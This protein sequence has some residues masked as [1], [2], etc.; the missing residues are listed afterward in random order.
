MNNPTKEAPTASRRRR[1]LMPL[2]LLLILIAGAFYIGYLMTSA[3]GLLDDKAA[4]IEQQKQ[5]C[6]AFG[7]ELDTSPYLI[8][9][10]QCILD[11][12]AVVVPQ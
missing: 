3:N 11:D 9:D 7:G 1:I 4:R 12:G 6:I 8:S 5:E 10:Y 2:L